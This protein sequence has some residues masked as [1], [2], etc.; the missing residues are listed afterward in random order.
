MSTQQRIQHIPTVVNL[1]INEN[2]S[3]NNPT[4]NYVA[5]GSTHNM[6]HLQTNPDMTEIMGP[7]FNINSDNDLYNFKAEEHDLRAEGR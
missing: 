6:T 3:P 2:L 5:S 7:R 1:N 4:L